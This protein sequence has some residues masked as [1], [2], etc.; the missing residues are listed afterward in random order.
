MK[1]KRV[2]LIVLD[3]LGVGELDDAKD[4]GDLGSNTLES[5]V[6]SGANIPNLEKMGIGNIDEV[7]FLSKPKKPTAAVARLEERSAGKDTTVGHWEIAGVVSEKAMPVYPN[8]FP[9][10]LLEQLSKETGRKIICNKAY[11]GTEVIKDYG[12]EH[13]ETGALIV[14][15]SADS[16]VQIAAHESVVPIKEL[17]EICEKARKIFMGEHAVGRVIARPFA[18]AYP[19]ARTKNRHDYSLTPPEKTM[20]EYIKDAEK[21]V[22]GVGKI[23]DIFA[24]VGITESIKT[25]D[26][27]DG[28]EQTLKLIKSD[29]SGLCFVNLVDFDML[30]GH[31]NDCEGYAK[32]L[33]QFDSWLEKALPMLKDDDVF[34]ITAD[35]GCDPATV[36]T[37]HSREH[38]PLIAYGKNIKPVNMGTRKSFADISA[39]VLEML[40]IN[41]KTQGESFNKIIMRG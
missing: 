29:F 33:G 9:Q 26:N 39:T 16:V 5:V 27:A 3:S 6:L 8:G 15:T 36:S 11:S 19:F 34:M 23:S 37:D 17:Y 20:L 4:Y 32:A 14:Y 18:G 31:R 35:H 13:M 22:I 30:F 38:T 21:S 41:E 10:N 40:E 28:M 24:G 25:K 1:I 7:H 2:F 12:K